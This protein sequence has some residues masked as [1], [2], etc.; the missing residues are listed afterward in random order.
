MIPFICS[1]GKGKTEN[2]GIT[3]VIPGSKGGGKGIDSTDEQGNFYVCVY[4]C[5][6]VYIKCICV[7]VFILNVYKYIYK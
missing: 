5:V 3:L 7:C 2:T 1:C 6:C 4:L